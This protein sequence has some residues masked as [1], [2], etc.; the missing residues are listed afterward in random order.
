MVHF[1]CVPGCR[2]QCQK[3]LLKQWIHKL[4]LAGTS[5]FDASLHEAQRLRSQTVKLIE[6]MSPKK[7]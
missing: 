1:C 3:G 4:E 6:A 5:P 7:S 2:L